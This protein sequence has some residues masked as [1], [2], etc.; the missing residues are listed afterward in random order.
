[1][2]YSYGGTIYSGFY[3]NNPSETFISLK[4]E[5]DNKNLLILSESG[6][7]D[8]SF[9]ASLNLEHFYKSMNEFTGKTPIP[10]IF[11]LGYH[12][13]RFSYEDL[14]EIKE[15]DN[16]FDKYEVPYDSIWLDIDHTDNKKYFT[17]DIKKFSKEETKKFFLDL[18]KK[19]RKVV[20]ILDPHIK[21]DNWYNVYYKS[22]NNYFIK[23]E[24]STDFIGNCWCG[25]SSFLDFFNKETINFWKNLIKKEE[26]YFYPGINNIHIWNDMNEPSVFKIQRNILSK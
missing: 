14:N 23:N 21:V 12:Q 19:G 3:W 26:E 25:D 2:S 17:Y 7:F 22:K 8:F 1:M 10:N 24:D 18:D 4:T 6:I 20:V 16:K 5:N 15:L 11:S 13:S 9:W